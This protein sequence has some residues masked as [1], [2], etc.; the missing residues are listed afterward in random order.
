MLK[1]TVELYMHRSGHTG[2]LI[3]NVT[4]IVWQNTSLTLR[5]QLLSNRVEV[6]YHYT[7]T[8]LTSDSEGGTQQLPVPGNLTYIC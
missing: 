2:T 8:E 3:E 4:F 5:Q 1:W 6:Q 7:L